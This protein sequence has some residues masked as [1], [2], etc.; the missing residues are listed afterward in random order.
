MIILTKYQ[1]KIT[2]NGK[3]LGK[4]QLGWKHV[5]NK[6]TIYGRQVVVRYE[7]IPMCM[8]YH[9]CKSGPV[10]TQHSKPVVDGF[11]TPRP[12]RVTVSC[13]WPVGHGIMES[14]CT[15]YYKVHYL[16][17]HTKQLIRQYS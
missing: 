11:F 3:N 4:E 1:L 10:T 14:F 6:F 13:S 17:C 5:C 8:F 7:G 12:A 2:C 16:Y 9:G 15:K